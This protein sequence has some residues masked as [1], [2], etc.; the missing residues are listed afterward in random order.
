MLNKRKMLIDGE[1]VDAVSGDM[2]GTINPATGETICASANMMFGLFPPSFQLLQ[3]HS[4]PLMGALERTKLP[5]GSPEFPSHKQHRVIGGHYR[6]SQT[7]P[8]VS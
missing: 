8:F 7:V 5:S 2:F 4:V 6:S 1:Y 3:D